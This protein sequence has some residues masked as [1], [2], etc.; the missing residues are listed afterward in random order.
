MLQGQLSSLFSL[1]SVLL[2]LS[3]PIFPILCSFE[4]QR[5]SR[6]TNKT[7]SKHVCTDT[8]IV[9][10]HTGA[11]TAFW[12]GYTQGSSSG[13]PISVGCVCACF[14]LLGG[15]RPVLVDSGA[16][17]YRLSV[18]SNYSFGPL[19]HSAW[20]CVCVCGCLSLT[21]SCAMPT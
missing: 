5:Y 6:V 2:Y 4:S 15:V 16:S 12:L 3:C 1:F 7:E 18:T 17:S 19:T 13:S 20:L 9:H 21:S 10:I 14:C 11:D 8:F